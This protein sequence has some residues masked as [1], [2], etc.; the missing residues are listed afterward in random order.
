[1]KRL[2][3]G[4]MALML[5][6]TGCASYEPDVDQT[7][8]E[9]DGHL[10]FKT[11][12][13]LVDCYSPGT[14]G[15]GGV[16]NDVFN[17]P[18][19]QRTF[20][21]TGTS[22]ESELNPVP[23]VTADGQ[24]LNVPG[25]V[26]FTLTQDCE[27]LYD[28]HKKVGVKY[29]AYENSGWTVLLNDYLGVAVTAALNDAVGDITWLDLYTDSAVRGAMEKE[30]NN[31]LQGRIN[32]SLGGEWIKVNGVSLSKPLASDELVK[33]LEASE[34]AKLENEAQKQRNETV[35]TRYQTISDCRKVASEDWCAIFFLADNG[36]IDLLPI[37]NGGNMNVTPRSGN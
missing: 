19:G 37:P 22:S 36:K 31:V 5:F 2:I 21:F 1:M 34:K 15:W 7:A 29:K 13:Q 30:L 4:L 26:K 14:S 12:K 6:L 23:V 24:T 28:F 27:A 35:R 33:G 25:F 8:I 3:V 18:A 32:A 10:L 16:G 11:D 9:Q 17:Y 20:S